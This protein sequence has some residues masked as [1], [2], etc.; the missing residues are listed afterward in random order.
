MQQHLELLKDC[1]PRSTEKRLEKQIPTQKETLSSQGAF[2]KKKKKQKMIE[3][4]TMGS[5]KID[6]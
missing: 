1:S 2:Y 5:W 3:N 6:E 4:I